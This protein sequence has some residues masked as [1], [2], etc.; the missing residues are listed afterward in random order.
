MAIIDQIREIDSHYGPDTGVI[1]CVGIMLDGRE[2]D[3]WLSNEGEELEVWPGPSFL[4]IT[5]C[6]PLI[7]SIR[8]WE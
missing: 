5:P 6:N 4:G 3:L 1:D 2:I 8:I 7:Q